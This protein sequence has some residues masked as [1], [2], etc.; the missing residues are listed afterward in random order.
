MSENAE[1][2]VNGKLVG[3]GFDGMFNALEEI[4]GSRM[5]ESAEPRWPN[6]SA[7][8]DEMSD[9]MNEPEESDLPDKPPIEDMPEDTDEEPEVPGEEEVPEEEFLSPGQARGEDSV[10]DRENETYPEE[11]TDESGTES[12]DDPASDTDNTIG[13]EPGSE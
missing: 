2:W 6:P 4:M 5:G 13:P 10:D 7:E 11:D 9:V 12:P 8:S 1:I 3:H